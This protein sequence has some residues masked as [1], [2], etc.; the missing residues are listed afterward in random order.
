M[1]FGSLSCVNPLECVSMNNQ[2]YKVKSEI[3][4]VNSNELLFYYFSIIT[5]KCIGSCND[6]NDLYAKLCVTDIA[7]H[8]NITVFNL[9][10]RTNETTHVKWYER[11]NVNVD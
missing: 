9:M 3:A 11:V 4:N 7:K 2:E 5:S 10:S 8:L 6:T 1:F